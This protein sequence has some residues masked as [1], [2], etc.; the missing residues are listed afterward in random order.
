MKKAYRMRLIAKGATVKFH[1]DF[2][3]GVLAFQEMVFNEDPE[4]YD[5]L[6]FASHLVDRMNKFMTD[7]VE[8]E[9]EEV[10]P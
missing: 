2:E 7:N 1:K 3:P 9:L 6:A 8:V 4:E 5:T 10:D